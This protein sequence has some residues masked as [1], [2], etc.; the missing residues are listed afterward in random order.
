[1]NTATQDL[2][3]GPNQRIDRLEKK[4]LLSALWLFVLF[5]FIF[6]DLHEIVKAEFLADA[7]NG[8]YD[9]REVTDAM[10]LLGGIIVEVPILMMLMAW[11]LPVRANRW[12]NVIVAPLF[13]LILIGAP[14]DL[15]DY[16][17]IGLVLIA[18]A[19]IVWHAWNWERS[20]SKAHALASQTPRST[21]SSKLGSLR[22]RANTTQIDDGKRV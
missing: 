22:H 8:I 2:S 4:A 16:F 13:G 7:L 17:H 21:T 6:R 1:M 19:I 9:G 15:D 12:A 20:T 10:F 3:T 11:V 18:L 5:N 14:G